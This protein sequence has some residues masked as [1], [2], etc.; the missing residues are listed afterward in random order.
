MKKQGKKAPVWFTVIFAVGLFAVVFWMFSKCG[1]NKKQVDFSAQWDVMTYEQR[2]S[3]LNKSID[4]R[5][6]SNA[7]DIHAALRNKIKEELRNKG[8]ASF[9]INPYIYEGL[10][11]I[12]EADSGWIHVPFKLEAKNDFGIAKEITGSVIYLYNPKN[13]TLEVKKWN[14]NQNN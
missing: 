5:L 10:A 4:E 13:N 12:V 11:N 14:I 3:F 6:F 7:S 9:I 8:T 2:D 1:G